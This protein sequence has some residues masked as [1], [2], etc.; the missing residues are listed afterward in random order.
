MQEKLPCS[1]GPAVPVQGAGPTM[2]PSQSVIYWLTGEK[3]PNPRQFWKMICPFLESLPFV[4]AESRRLH[5]QWA[6][7][8]T[9]A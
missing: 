3:H 7:S 5:W 9:G 6:G 2:P 4:A 8:A 1:V